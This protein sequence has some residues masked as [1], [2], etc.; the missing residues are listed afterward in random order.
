MSLVS[1]GPARDIC[2]IR[3]AEL[4]FFPPPTVL[5]FVYINLLI[6]YCTFSCSPST[7][8]LMWMFSCALLQHRLQFIL[9]RNV[10]PQSSTVDYTS[11]SPHS[12]ASTLL[13]GT[14]L[15]TTYHCPHY[16]LHRFR[17]TANGF[18]FGIL[19]PRRWGRYIVSK[20]R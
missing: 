6:K 7:A 3:S 12:L 18:L 16:S 19:D 2:T 5:I 17:A 1:P 15:L 10:F 13:A 8:W 9:F 11:S 14:T 4:R 20:R